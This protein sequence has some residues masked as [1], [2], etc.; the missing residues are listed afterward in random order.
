MKQRVAELELVMF[1][2]RVLGASTLRTAEGIWCPTEPVTPGVLSTDETS[3]N[4]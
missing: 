3:I 4:P 1:S 2:G